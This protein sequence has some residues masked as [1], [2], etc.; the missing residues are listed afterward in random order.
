MQGEAQD[1]DVRESQLQRDN[2]RLQSQVQAA[3]GLRSE[4]TRAA[5]AA[6]RAQLL[7]VQ[8]ENRQLR[9]DI[10]ALQAETRQHICTSI[11][12]VCEI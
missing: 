1:A 11:F 4:I 3:E 2:A 7:E 5:A 8:R 12:A 6:D 9:R 10:E